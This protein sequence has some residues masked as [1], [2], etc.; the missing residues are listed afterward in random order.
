MNECFCILKVKLEDTVSKDNVL[1]CI[2]NREV[3]CCIFYFVVNSTK[4]LK[5]LVTLSDNDMS[6]HVIFL[7]S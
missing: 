4:W 7:I 3:K 2:S 1:L 5:V 6:L